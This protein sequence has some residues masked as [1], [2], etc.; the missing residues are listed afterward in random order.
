MLARYFAKES[1][2]TVGPFPS[3]NNLDA[4]AKKQG[5][6]RISKGIMGFHLLFTKH[7]Y[8]QNNCEIGD[9]HELMNN[10][11]G[12]PRQYTLPLTVFWNALYLYEEG[13]SNFSLFMNFPAK[14]C[15]VRNI[16][17]FPLSSVLLMC[18]PLRKPCCSSTVASLPPP[19]VVIWLLG[20]LSCVETHNW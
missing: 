1:R 11:L 2:P 4:H 9:D 6:A 3:R 13:I 18:F 20:A 5:K 12:H 10:Q 17:S 19:A 8:S 16:K 7:W 15:N 14:P